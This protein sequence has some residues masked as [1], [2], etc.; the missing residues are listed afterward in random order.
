MFEQLYLLMNIS[1]DRAI[2]TYVTAAAL[3]ACGLVAQSCA[4]PSTDTISITADAPHTRVRYLDGIEFEQ[5]SEFGRAY[6]D[7][8]FFCKPQI[9]VKELTDLRQGKT[10]TFEVTGISAKLQL[11]LIQSLPIGVKDPLRKHE[12]THCAMTADVYK[13]APKAAAEIAK[14][15]IGRRIVIES[16][17][18]A[19]DARADAEFQARKDFKIEY[20][21]TVGAQAD[22]LSKI[23]DRVTKHG[24]NGVT[25]EDGVRRSIEEHNRKENKGEKTNGA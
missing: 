22:E 8:S 25:N 6:S 12:E 20:Q 15:M 19:N 9:Q 23:F 10:F 5:H 17:G 11:E 4:K 24:M 21:K 3:I 2:S 16:N 14:K 18:N 7:W 1:S 13:Q